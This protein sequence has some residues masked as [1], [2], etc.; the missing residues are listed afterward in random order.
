MFHACM[1]SSSGVCRECDVYPLL[2]HSWAQH[3]ALRKKTQSWCMRGWWV[4]AMLQPFTLYS[5]ILN[6][7]SP[8][9]STFHL[10]SGSHILENWESAMGKIKHIQLL[11]HYSTLLFSMLYQQ[12]KLGWRTEEGVYVLA[13]TEWV[14]LDQKSAYI[15]I[16]F[17]MNVGYDIE[18]S[19]INAYA[20]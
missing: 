18:S 2:W 20:E 10:L 17:V 4:G 9:Q 16:T 8:K 12:L 5:C 3:I 19:S 14:I 13:N 7:T 1:T 15:I 11:P 6:F